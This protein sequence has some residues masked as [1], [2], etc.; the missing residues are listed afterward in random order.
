MT[1]REQK[2]MG[3]TLKV[4]N[5]LHD[6]IIC[7]LSTQY[8]YFIIISVSILQNPSLIYCWQD[9]PLHHIPHFTTRSNFGK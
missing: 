9:S 2:E 4:D 8:L 6:I 5:Y 1:K 3:M 7:F